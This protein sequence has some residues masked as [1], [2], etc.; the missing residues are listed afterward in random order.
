MALGSKSSVWSL[1]IEKFS[2]ANIDINS[3]FWLHLIDC[4]VTA[5]WKSALFI[6]EGSR[7]KSGGCGT[8]FVRFIQQNITVHIFGYCL[9]FLSVV[10]YEPAQLEMRL[11][12]LAGVVCPLMYYE[13]PTYISKCTLKFSTLYFVDSHH[14]IDNVQTIG[15]DLLAMPLEHLKAIYCND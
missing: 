13:G 9:E 2:S 1:S 5:L 3:S 8:W 10:S 12:R 15:I 4:S 6:S 11:S 7:L 14:S